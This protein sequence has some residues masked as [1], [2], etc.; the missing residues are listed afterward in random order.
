MTQGMMVFDKDAVLERVDG[1]LELLFSL[2]DILEDDLREK[3]PSIRSALDAGELQ[4]VSET[5]HSLKSALGNLGAMTAHGAAL[6]LE[7]SGRTRDVDLARADFAKLETASAEFL[8][9]F[10]RIMRPAS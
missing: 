8:V 4:R 2:I 3:L 7:K 9:E 6:A 10:N 5:A 1:D